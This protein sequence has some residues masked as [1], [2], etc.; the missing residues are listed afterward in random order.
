M[1]KKGEMTQKML[2]V[3]DSD[4]PESTTYDRNCGRCGWSQ[5]T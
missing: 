1:H 5:K 4:F 3:W 2:I